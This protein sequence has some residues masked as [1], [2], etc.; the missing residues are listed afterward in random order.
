ME[1]AVRARLTELLALAE[2][3]DAAAAAGYVVYRG[4]DEAR[5]WKDVCDYT[6]DPEKTQVDSV[7][8]RIAEIRKA[9][10]LVPD[11]FERKTEGEGE[12]LALKYKAGDKP[13]LFA[14]LA[15]KGTY[16]LGDID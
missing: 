4:P 5:K 9:G 16:A 3:G 6:K 10:P 7:L 14:F 1:D 8:R 15:V 12:W 13:V 11:G 2:K